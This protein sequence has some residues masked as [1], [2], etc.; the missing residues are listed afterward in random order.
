[1][2]LTMH[3]HRQSFARTLLN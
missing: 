2:P 1:M 3:K